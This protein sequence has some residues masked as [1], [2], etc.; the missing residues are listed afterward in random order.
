MCAAANLDRTTNAVQKSLHRLSTGLR[1]NSSADGSAAL[2]I[3]ETQKVQIS[4]LAVAMDNTDRA[5]SLIAT[6]EGAF[7]EI[8]AL[9]VSIRDK[10]LDSANSGVYG[11]NELAKNQSEVEDAIAA[12]DQIVSQTQFGSKNLLDGSNANTVTIADGANDLDLAFKDS[13][14]QTGSVNQVTIG[15][16]SEASFSI[17]HGEDF[18]L[19]AH[20]TPNVQGIGPGVVTLNITQASEGATIYNGKF[21]GSLDNAATFEV[22]YDGCAPI[23]VTV[24]PGANNLAGLRL[25]IDWALHAADPA[26]FNEV[27]CAVSKDG[28]HINLHTFDEGSNATLQISNLNTAAIEEI[29]LSAQSDVGEVGIIEVDGHENIITDIESEF[30]YD[31]DPTTWS[32]ATLEDANGGSFDVRLHPRGLVAGSTIARISAAS[33][34]IQIA[35]GD[36]VGFATG[37]WTEVRNGDGDAIDVMVGNDITGTGTET[38]AVVDN[39]MQFQIGANAGQS[40]KIGIDDMATN[41]IGRGVT[42]DSGFNNLKEIDVSTAAKANDALEVIDQAIEDV[43]S[44]RSD[45]GAFQSGMLEHVLTNLSVTHQNLQS[46]NS[47]VVDTDFAEEVAELTKQQILAQAGTSVL[48]TANQMSQLALSLL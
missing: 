47:V 10:A 32:E 1:I 7:T 27:L 23:L 45:L 4:G 25:A 35:G 6:A 18:G 3:S 42:N 24:A 38:L 22:S 21:D 20:E 36:K 29:G 2:A 11:G 33:G 44:Q 39:S 46:A 37:E 48:A 40:V 9:L 26:L 28:E 34:S 13:E 12:I 30:L 31:L 17:D 5:I 15:D 41:M 16:Y 43:L 19:L 8:N 14:L